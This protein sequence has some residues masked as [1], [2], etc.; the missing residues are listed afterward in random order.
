MSTLPH[1][2]PQQDEQ[3]R[4]LQLERDFQKRAEEAA[5]QQDDDE[6]SN[7]IDNESVQ[8]IQGLLRTAAAQDRSNQANQQQN[9]SRTNTNNQ[10]IRGVLSPQP[11]GS[12][13]QSTN[14]SL[15]TAIS[16]QGLSNS[17]NTYGSQ[18]ETSNVNNLNQNLNLSQNLNQNLNNQ[19]L[20]P[21]YGP[22][23]GQLGTSQKPA[24]VAAT[25]N[26]ERE[27][28]R[29]I[30]ELKRKQSEFDESHRK[31]EEEIRQQ[32]HQL[33][34][35][36]QQMQQL[37]HQQQAN[38]RREQGLHPG[39]LRLENLVINGPNSPCKLYLKMFS[40]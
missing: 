14:V 26:D 12:Q 30:E 7:E 33:Q 10:S 6:E 34:M 15:H 16:G 20:S 2:T 11:V 21:T 1:R 25:Q 19:P 27:R 35:H 36:Q 38:L 28:Q 40:F 24:I 3:L 17:G 8:R 18:N 23:L 37:Y 22:P 32:Q 39:M 4:A 9:L 13:L 29:R 5:N 31:R